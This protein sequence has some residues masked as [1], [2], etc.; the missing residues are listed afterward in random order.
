MKLPSV[1]RLI[2]LG[3]GCSTAISTGISTGKCFE[4]VRGSR[5]IVVVRPS[6]FAVVFAEDVPDVQSTDLVSGERI[7]FCQYV[8]GYAKLSCKM[9]GRT[10]ALH[11]ISL[12]TL[13]RLASDNYI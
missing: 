6:G 11:I 2:T 13:T 3:R 7:P 5:L 1:L 8:G 9:L 12:S 4:T 10:C